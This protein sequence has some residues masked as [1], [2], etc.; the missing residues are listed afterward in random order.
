MAGASAASDIH[1]GVGSRLLLLYGCTGI[2]LEGRCMKICIS[3][4]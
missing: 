1:C 2:K 3:S 4:A